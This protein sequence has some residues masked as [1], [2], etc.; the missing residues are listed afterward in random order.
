MSKRKDRTGEINYN[1]NGKKM[2]IIKYN[3]ANDIDVRFDNGVIIKNKTYDAFL[4]GS[5]SSPF[6]GVGYIGNEKYSIRDDNGKIIKSYECWYGLLQRCYDEEH[7]DKYP[8]YKDCTVCEEWL[9]YKNFSNWYDKNYYD[10]NGERTNLDKD[11][12]HKGNKI[13]NPD[14]C[15][16]TPQ[17]INNLFVKCNASRGDLPIGVVFRDKCDNKFMAECRNTFLGKNVYLGLYST[18]EEAFE[19]YKIYKEKH[20]KEVADYY[21]DIIPNKLYDALYRYEVE[22]TD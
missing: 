21:K 3:Y 17:K 15:V 5:I 10:C 18:P 19:A 1:N 2:T 22:I 13:Y 11:I 6:W 7:R 8:T 12:I 20:I 14:N 9:N 4:K 16:F